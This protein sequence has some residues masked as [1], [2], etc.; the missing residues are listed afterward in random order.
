M[1]R[2]LFGMQ[3]QREASRH[4]GEGTGT[5]AGAWAWCIQTQKLEG[6]TKVEPDRKT[7]QLTLSNVLPPQGSKHSTAIRELPA[8][9][10][11]D[12]SQASPTKSC[13][14]VVEI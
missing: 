4:G 6:E 5:A 12:V 3:F 11:R 13:K 9:P 1:G 14:A 2:V 7:S 8:G 10:M